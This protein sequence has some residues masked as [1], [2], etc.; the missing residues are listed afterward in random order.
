[1]KKLISCLILALVAILLFDNSFSVQI[2]EVDKTEMV[3]Q[4]NPQQTE[5]ISFLKTGQAMLDGERWSHPLLTSNG[6]SEDLSYPMTDQTHRTTLTGTVM[7][8]R[9]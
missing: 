2:M 7:L 6:V 3:F 5:I 1:M 4:K 8:A 9:F